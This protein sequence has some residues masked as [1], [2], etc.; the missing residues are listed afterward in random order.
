MTGSILNSGN[1]I[2][3]ADGKPFGKLFL[4]IEMIRWGLYRWNHSAIA[5]WI[6][7]F[8]EEDV[9]VAGYIFMYAAL[10]HR[11]TG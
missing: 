5:Q 1:A 11:D 7:E 9:I 2:A 8:I 6:C 3:G 4:N 10:K